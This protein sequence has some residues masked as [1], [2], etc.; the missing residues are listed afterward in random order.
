[1]LYSDPGQNF[2]SI[3]LLFSKYTSLQGDCVSGEQR[4]DGVETLP[5]VGADHGKSPH[6]CILGLSKVRGQFETDTAI[7]MQISAYFQPYLFRT[8][9]V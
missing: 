5:Q 8:G 6:L 4:G 2:G 7:D 3:S 9:D 1:M